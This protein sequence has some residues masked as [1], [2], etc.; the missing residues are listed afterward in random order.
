MEVWHAPSAARHNRWRISLYD[1]RQ[2]GPPRVAEVQQT[3]E[4]FTSLV[5]RGNDSELLLASSGRDGSRLWSWKHAVSTTLEPCGTAQWARAPIWAAAQTHD[6][7][8]LL[9]VG[10]SQARIFAAES[11]KQIATL[12]SHAA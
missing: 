11:G 12:G 4:S 1:L 10:G 7:Q 5:F 3:G 9:T 6:G 2:G 8:A